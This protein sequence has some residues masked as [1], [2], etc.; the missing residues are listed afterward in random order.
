MKRSAKTIGKR[1]KRAKRGTRERKRMPYLSFPSHPLGS[2]IFFLFFALSILFFAFYPTK[3]PG[4]RLGEELNRK[5][6]KA[7]Y[8]AAKKKSWKKIQAYTGFKYFTYAIR[9]LHQLS[10]NGSN[11][12]RARIISGFFFVVSVPAKIFFAFKTIL[13]STCGLHL[14]VICNVASSKSFGRKQIYCYCHKT[15]K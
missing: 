3:E 12:V 2:L 6:I 15:S 8:A 11:P 10:V 4:P 7:T 14:W 13:I 5:E 9:V 1:T